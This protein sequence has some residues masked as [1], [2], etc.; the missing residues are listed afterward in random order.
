M[1]DLLPA[2]GIIDQDLHIDVSVVHVVQLVFVGILSDAQEIIILQCREIYGAEA[3]LDVL[4][5]NRSLGLLV[6]VGHRVMNQ[7]VAK[8]RPG[9]DVNSIRAG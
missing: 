4:Q 1:S 5:R 2:C 8:L 9:H 6:R 7:A 3:C